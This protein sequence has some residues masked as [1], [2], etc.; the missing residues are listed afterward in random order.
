MGLLVFQDLPCDLLDAVDLGAHHRVGDLVVH[1]PDLPED[2]VLPGGGLLGRLLGGRLPLWL[3]GVV[4]HLG[5]EQPALRQIQ[6]PRGQDA[7]GQHPAQV[8]AQP[9]HGHAEGSGHGGQGHLTVGP[10]VGKVVQIALAAAVYADTGEQHGQAACREHQAGQ[11]AYKH[12]AIR[13]LEKLNAGGDG[14]QGEDGG[15]NASADDKPGAALTLFFEL[16]PLVLPGVP[17]VPAVGLGLLRPWLGLGLFCFLLGLG[18][19][20]PVLVGAGRRTLAAL[21]WRGALGT[22]RASHHLTA[23]IEQV[24]HGAPGGGGGF[25]GLLAVALLLL[26]V[27]SHQLAHQPDHGDDLGDAAGGQ[28]EQH[29][30]ANPVPIAVVLLGRLRLPAP[31]EGRCTLPCVIAVFVIIAVVVA[32][33]VWSLLAGPRAGTALCPPVVGIITV[34][35]RHAC[36]PFPEAPGGAAKVHADSII[37]FC[38]G[39]V[40]KENLN[41][42]WR[43]SRLA[44]DNF[45]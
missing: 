38:F 34:F 27:H 45:G 42:F 8:L 26:I 31:A 11:H 13:I 5:E 14:A 12:I 25:L 36:P 9:A 10:D 22:A 4:A 41:F 19:L 44:I 16:A 40:N 2:I 28:Q 23:Q 30:D 24:G 7:L 21:P 32:L 37:Y 35:I 6:I 33:L 17:H 43:F 15:H 20:L 3:G 39:G 18:S 1:L 29:R